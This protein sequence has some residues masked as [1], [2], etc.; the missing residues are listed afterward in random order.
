MSLNNIQLKPQLLADLYSDVLVE[1]H[2]SPVPEKQD[3]R[4]LGGNRRQVAVVVQHRGIP[5]LPDQELAFLTN[6]LA[7][8][9]LSI[10]DIAII[11]FESMEELV[12]QEG[13]E[14]LNSRQVLLFGVEPLAIGLPIHFPVF[15][16]QQFSKRTYVQAPPL[17]EIENDKNLKQKLWNSLKSLFGI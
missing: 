4:T 9:K 12:L 5:F 2:A 1:T 17:S 15:Q 8:C 11:N 6:I 16:L 14:Q 7:A 10:A 3:F 13:L